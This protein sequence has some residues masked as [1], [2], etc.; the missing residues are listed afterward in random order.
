[1]AN[2]NHIRYFEMCIKQPDRY[3]A[4]GGEASTAFALTLFFAFMGDSYADAPLLC[5]SRPSAHRVVLFMPISCFGTGSRIRNSFRQADK[6][7]H[8]FR[9]RLI[10]MPSQ[11]H[12]RY[13][14]DF[15]AFNPCALSK[16]HPRTR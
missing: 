11:L 1:M 10:R 4:G 8:Y 12:L 15:Q 16:H 2:P 3:T 5:L 6:F 14:D 13:M 9:L 7:G